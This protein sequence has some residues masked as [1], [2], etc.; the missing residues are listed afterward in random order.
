MRITVQVFKPG[1][2]E[3][4]TPAWSVTLR[5]GDSLLH[6]FEL[7]PA[8]SRP[9]DPRRPEN[10]SGFADDSTGS[11]HMLAYLLWGSGAAAAVT[12]TIFFLEAHHLQRQ[13]DA[14]FERNCPEGVDRSN[15]RC[16]SSTPG[17]VKAANWRTAALLT[18]VGAAVAAMGGTLVY[19]L[20]ASVSSST[21]EEA[22]HD[23]DVHAWVSPIGIGVSGSF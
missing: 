15:A 13:S 4:T 14:D 6:S 20:D 18:G 16:A 19:W 22:S 2:S 17:D 5:P 1:S 21:E 11:S 23:V 8:I 3:V 10:P 12:S 9:I 7:D